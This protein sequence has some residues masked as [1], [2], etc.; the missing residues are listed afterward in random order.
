MRR[1]TWWSP[2][3]S[4]PLPASTQ[5]AAWNRPAL[6]G[7]R[8]IASP[9]THLFAIAR[10]GYGHGGNGFRAWLLLQG[11]EDCRTQAGGAELEGARPAKEQES[12]LEA[13]V[14]V[15]GGGGGGCVAAIR[16]A[17]AGAKVVIMEKCGIL[18]GSTNVSGGA[19]NARRPVSPG[20]AGH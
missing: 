8:W 6:D 11:V 13:D 20:Q 18:G 19:L 5:A 1:S 7:T 3:P 10:C 14:C 2:L 9:T 15:V 4:M 17:Q 16:A 12:A